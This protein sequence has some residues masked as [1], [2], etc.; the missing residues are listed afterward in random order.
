MKNWKLVLPLTFSLIS[1]VWF[2]FLMG[3]STYY[4]SG[5]LPVNSLS[6]WNTQPDGSGADPASFGSNNS[7]IIQNGHSMTL[8]G[9][10]TWNVGSNGVLTIQNGG[11]W[12][13]NS[14][15]TVTIGIFNIYGGGQFVHNSGTAVVPGNTRNFANSTN[16]ANGN[17]TYEIQNY[18]TS[19]INSGTG[20]T[21]G[22]VRVNRTSTTQASGHSSA[23]A[24]VQGNFT[25]DA[26]GSHEFRFTNNQSDAHTISGNL[27]VNG[28]TLNIKSGNNSVVLS[29]G[30][31]LTIAG[32]TLTQTSG[33][34]TINFTGSSSNYTL[35]SGIFTTNLIN[36]N[37]NNGAHLKLNDNLVLSTSRVFTVNGTIDF[38]IYTISGNGSF[39]L[40]S[41]ATLK[42]ENS[43]GLAGSIA[44]TGTSIFSTSANYEFNGA[45]QDILS[46]LPSTV[47][48]LTLSGS[49]TKTISGNRTINGNLT[50]SGTTL[51]L[52]AGTTYNV[53]GNFTNDGGSA[54]L[55]GTTMV[56]DG[57]N[58]QSIGGSSPTTFGDL[59][60]SNTNVGGVA[61]NNYFIVSGDLR[62]SQGS[63]MN[64]AGGISDSP[65]DGSLF[66]NN[67]E[68]YAGTW[69]SSSSTPPAM[70]QDNTYFSVSG[71]KRLTV[72][73]GAPLPIELISF[74][75][76]K[77][78][79]TTALEWVTASELNNE[80]FL[81]ERSSDGLLFRVIGEVLGKGT[82][83]EPNNYK[84]LDLTP[85][86]G[87]NYY[88]LK[89]IDH[90]GQY[91]YSN[92]VSIEFSGVKRQTQVFP[93]LVFQL[94][95]VRVPE[96][97]TEAGTIRIIDANGR[98]TKTIE[99][100]PGT[101]ELTIN[102]IDL[103]QGLHVLQVQNGGE[104]EYFKFV[105]L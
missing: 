5:S 95:H 41:A 104:M 78:Q 44:V 61:S 58:S 57:T 32:G 65:I 33:T 39:N 3:Q 88:R 70:Y 62:I 92:V 26:H 73:M 34:S 105:K 66:L 75:A 17:G 7:W 59:T 60:I 16:G 101:V 19:P 9:T 76:K 24:I 72:A 54:L 23:F 4:S 100:E 14:S 40:N 52:A 12:T 29:V 46:L 49:G 71:T 103:Q 48:N 15:G 10:S 42:T 37:I 93:Y 86:I 25:M 28:G 51:S 53:K 47:N 80:K 21:W 64:L 94:L 67:F 38:G 87:I 82:T 91:E 90:D 81:V 18:G 56:F 84:F 69:G 99:Y 55:G 8:S 50:I 74:T 13:N 11:I 22:N 6:S 35:S 85:A 97:I 20:I 30:G 36:F 27:T 77:E 83:Y 68:Q 45:S 2:G 79:Q 43:T 98:V 102:V 1:T 31:D 89:Q 96:T 63:K